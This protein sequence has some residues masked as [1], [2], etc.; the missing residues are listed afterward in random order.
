MADFLGLCQQS[1]QVVVVEMCKF[2]SPGSVS[3]SKWSLW[4]CVRVRAQ[5]AL[6]LP[7]VEAHRGVFVDGKQVW[8]VGTLPAVEASGRRGDVYV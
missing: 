5:E 4:R 3:R 6:D 1:K 2:E 7:A 8:V